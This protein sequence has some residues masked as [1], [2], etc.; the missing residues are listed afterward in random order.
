MTMTKPMGGGGKNVTNKRKRGKTK[1][2]WNSLLIQQIKWVRG[3]D[4][5]KGKNQRKEWNSR[6]I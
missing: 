4:S 3:K 6:L 1:R 2:E 5:K